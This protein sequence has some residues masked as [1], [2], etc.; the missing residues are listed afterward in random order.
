MV[1]AFA[2]FG[3]VPHEILFDQIASVMNSSSLVGLERR[4]V[5]GDLPCVH[6]ST[7]VT[8]FAIQRLMVRRFKPNWRAKAVLKRPCSSRC[9]SSAYLPFDQGHPLR[10]GG[11]AKL[12]GRRR[13]SYNRT[14]HAGV[15]IRWGHSAGGSGITIGAYRKSR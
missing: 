3:G 10:C 4:T 12:N 2:F 8:H 7:R 1:E 6:V 5:E 13:G 9:P 14:L 11:S 15:G